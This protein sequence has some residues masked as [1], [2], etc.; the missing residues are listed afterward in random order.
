MEGVGLFT[1][2]RYRD[3][4]ASAMYI[5]TDVISEDGWHLGWEGNIIDKVIAEIVDVIAG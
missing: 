5:V 4:S 1:I 3:C 2:A